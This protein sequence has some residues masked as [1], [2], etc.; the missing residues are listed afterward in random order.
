MVTR[1]A[2]LFLLWQPLLLAGLVAAAGFGQVTTPVPISQRGSTLYERKGTHDA[3]NIR[4]EF[5]NYGMVGNYPNDPGNVDLTTFHS[6]EVPKGSGVNYSDGTTPFI[7]AKAKDTSGVDFFL[8]ETG[9]RERQA[10][11]RHPS[12]ARGS[13]QRFEPRPGYFQESTTINRALSPAISNDTLTWPATW[14][15]RDGTWDGKW[16]GY[17]GKRPAADQESFTVMDDDMYDGY[18]YF[19]DSRDKTRL[20][21]GTRVE[22]RGFQW[23]NPQSGNVIFWHYDITNEST[24]DYPK[25]GDPENI[26]F[27]IYMDS[28]VGGEAL[29]CD[30]VYES[31]DDN[32]HWD[33]SDPGLNLVYTWDVY[34]HGVGLGSSCSHTGYLGYAYL[35]TPG[36]EFD[37]VDNDNDGI[38]D[39][40]RGPDRGQKIVGQGNISAYVTAHY[41]MAK[42]E[43]FYG[44]L[45]E[46]PAFKAGEWWTGD[47]NLNWVA[48][49]D[50]LGSDGIGP[51]NEGYNGPDADG[52]EGNGI[53][54]QGEPNFGKTDP[55]ESDQ[56][57]LTGFKMNRIG[58]GRGNPSTVVDDIQ[59][60]TGIGRIGDWPKR[61]YE[62]FSSGDP[63]ARFDNATVENYNI[64]FLFASGPFTLKAQLRERFSLALAYGDDFGELKRT[65]AVVQAIYNANYQFSTPPP[66]PTVKAET[67]DHYVQITWDDVA[68]NATN[69][70]VGYN[71]FEGYRVYRSTDPEFVDPKVIVSARGTTIGGNGKPM[72]QFD[73]VDGRSGYSSTSVEGISYYLGSE[74]GLTHTYRDETVTNGQFYYYAVCSY[75][76]GPTLVRGNT[77]FTYFPSESPITVSRTLR[78]GLVLPK[79]VVAVRPNPKVAGYTAARVSNV[80]R[81]GGTGVGTV[82]S[83]VVS[84]GL[85]PKGHVFKV[86]FNN[87]PDS[88]HATTYNLTDTTD[89]VVLF[90][91]GNIFDGSANGQSALGVLP[92]VKT[93]DEIVVN[94]AAW[95][96]PAVTDCQLSMSY[97]SKYSKN[98][99]RDGFPWDISI[100]FYDHI[101]DTAEA[102]LV[103]LDGTPVKFNVIAHTPNGDERLKFQFNDDDGDGSL[104]HGGSHEVITVMYGPSTLAPAYRKTWLIQMTGDKPTTKNPAP[105][106][107]YRIVFDRPLNTGDEFVFSATAEVLG[108]VNADSA[109]TPYVVPNPYLGAASFESSNFGV[110]G[111]GERRIEFRNVVRGCT[112]R[113]YTVRG[114]LVRTLTH[115]GSSTSMVPWDLRTKDNL[116]AAPGLYVYHVDGGA[117]GSH[118]GKFA[119]IK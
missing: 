116:D 57:G 89:H 102:A 99:R 106:D 87:D 40:S 54:D 104:S 53:P 73:A 81:T 98:V 52:T 15:D 2:R 9:Y 108:E 62:Q 78:G 7:L 75:D 107:E 49:F 28:G 25:S 29:S 33:N 21:L 34:G 67:G 17:F 61:L 96:S 1:T 38:T 60:G 64:G 41:S 43:K 20:G 24:T 76:Y 63:S 36:K 109:G 27:G 110:V 14:A 82:T 85:V 37:G 72:A 45:T 3:N 39:E 101:V 26:I 48:A 65:V 19:P 68:E 93:P 42:F 119:I 32:A 12:G 118:I 8:M 47:E 18:D 97:V 51:K 112:I 86:T 113:I 115:D 114:E 55:D 22:V 16:N 6:V 58:P 79:N 70:I 56:I 80:T 5:W 66:T 50:D 105:G 77:T 91:T 111:R 92:I 69:P 46:R 90:R 44:P 100:K 103:F 59:F 117:A 35:E 95:A 10:S 31:D 30:G 4:T 94:S 13:I 71:A 23:S 83:R 11:R 74:S 88:V 84:S